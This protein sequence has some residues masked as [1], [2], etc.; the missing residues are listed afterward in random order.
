MA[1]GS[2]W[3]VGARDLVRWHV[4]AHETEA[5]HAGFSSGV[6]RSIAIHLDLKL[7]GFVDLGPMDLVV[8]LVL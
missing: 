6:W 7:S 5:V 1:R 8:A 4:L 3:S 2:A